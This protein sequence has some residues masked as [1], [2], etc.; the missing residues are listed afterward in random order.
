M[1]TQDY[2]LQNLPG[3]STE[4]QTALANLGFSTT[5]QLYRFGQSP[6]HQAALAQQLRLPLRYVKKWVI[7]ADL[8]RVP[9]VGCEFNGLL[10]HAGI[11]SPEQLAQTSAQT[12]AVQV[13]RLHVATLRRNDLSPTPDQVKLWITNARVLVQKTSGV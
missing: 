4:H 10:L 8:A 6:S 7:L 5:T 9:T 12:L 1:I 3:L 2:P 13:K 11:T